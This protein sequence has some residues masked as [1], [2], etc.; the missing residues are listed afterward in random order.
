[1]ATGLTVGAGLTVIVNVKGVPTQALAVGVTVI[2]A[3]TGVV[4]GFVAVNTGIPPVPL[5]AS[6][7]DGSLFVQANVVPATGLVK[8]TAVVVA[9]L[10]YATLATGS[11]VVVGFTVMVKVNGTPGHAFAEGVTVIVATTGVVPALVAVNE[12]ISPVPL[13]ANPIEGVLLVQANVVP[14]TGPDTVMIAVVAPLQ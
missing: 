13:A 6:P 9:P 7:I 12:G 4:P 2:V 11:T 10:Q 1:L 3:T 5:A 14:A 8:A